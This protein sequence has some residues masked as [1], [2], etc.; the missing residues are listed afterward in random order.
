MDGEQIPMKIGIVGLGYVGLVTAAVLANNGNEV[1]GVDIAEER[2]EKLNSGIMPIYEPDLKDRVVSAGKK[3]HFTSNFGYLR[4]CDAV[5]LCVPTPNTN[6]KVDLGYVT[7]ASKTVSE[8]DYSGPIIIKS[9]VPPGTARKISEITG[10][11]IISNPEFTR[12]GSAVYD[13]EHPDRVVIGGKYTEIAEKIWAFT[14]SPALITSNENAELIKYASN[15]FLATKISFINQIADLCETI[16]G[17][18]VQV[19]ARGM[20]MDHRI[21]MEF[22]KAGLGYGGSCFPKDT[23]AI[24]AFARERGVNLSII[25]SVIAYNES[26]VE[27]LAGKISEINGSL[28]GRKVCVLGLSFKDNTDDLRESKSV[29]LVNELRK[30]GAEVSIYDPVVKNYGDLTICS[31]MEKCVSA[32]D[33][34]VTATEWKEFTNLDPE[35]LADKVVFDLRRVLDPNKVKLTMGVG[36]GKN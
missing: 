24:S 9:T 15:A 17:S 13:T 33:I 27:N 22:L 5:C 7:S 16:P 3:L 12:E 29:A 18:D 1:I 19:V 20:G 32:A 8:Q 14:S 26:R 4:T 2:I 30:Q 35:L 11:N 36:I 28:K 34:V 10:L 6:G 21:G 31:N 25:D 23:A